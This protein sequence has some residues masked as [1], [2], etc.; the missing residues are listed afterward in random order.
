MSWKN[1]IWFS[2]GL[3]LGFTIASKISAIEGAAPQN[4]VY[5]GLGALV[6]SIIALATEISG[7]QNVA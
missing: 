3:S 5:L 4:I 6:I 2:I 7:H 1:A